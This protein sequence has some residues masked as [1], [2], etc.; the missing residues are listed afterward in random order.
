MTSSRPFSPRRE[1]RLVLSARFLDLDGDQPLLEGAALPGAPVAETEGGS[2]AAQRPEAKDLHSRAAEALGGRLT[3]F[4]AGL[5]DQLLPVS[6]QLGFPDESRRRGALQ[7]HFEGP[8][9][10]CHDLSV[11][12]RA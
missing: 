9:N 3:P 11:P 4:G 2:A 1:G 5:L 6:R 12:A 7:A 10:G 8:T